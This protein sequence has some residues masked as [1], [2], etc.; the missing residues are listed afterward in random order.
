MKVL[1]VANQKGGVGKTTTAVN[2]GAALAGLGHRTLL[3]DLDPQANATLLAGVDPYAREESMYHVLVRGAPLRSVVTRSGVAGLDVAPAHI[4]LAGAEG[5]LMSTTGREQV[6]REALEPVAGDYAF[7]LID[8]QPSL[9]ILVVNALSAADEVVVPVEAGV[10]AFMGFRQ[11]EETVRLIQRRV[12]RR[13]KVAGVLV[14][15][16]DGRT[17]ERPGVPGAPPRRAR[18]ALPALRDPHRPDDA[19]QG[20]RESGPSRSSTATRAPRWRRSTSASRRS[21]SV[22]SRRAAARTR[23]DET[24]QRLVD[25]RPGV[26]DL[27]EGKRLPVAAIDANPQQP[28]KG[29]LEGIE[30]LAASIREY[31]LLQP[32]VVSPRPDGRYICIAGHRRLAAYRHLAA[33]EQDEPTRWAVIPAVERDDHSDEWLVLGLLENLSRSDL[34]DAEIISGLSVLHDLRGWHQ[35]EIARR[36]G[37]Q[38]VD[39]AVLPRR[40]RSLRQRVR[41]DRAALGGEGARHRAGQDARR[42][43]GGARRR[44][45]ECPAA[46]DPA[47]GEGRRGP[48]RAGRAGAA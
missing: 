3:V 39:H 37:V 1:A 30:E 42:P 38:R 46:R 17:T 19:G 8:C 24:W 36:L 33:T 13:L 34:T 47:A 20:R 35:G 16:F 26:E 23:A 22:A 10:F 41:A 43:A 15:K 45:P 6:L 9:G 11:L 18:R 29:P 44:A 5:E 48:G 4:D 31:G 28:R 12:N 25:N 27:L 14:T 7:A 40:R 2:L 32:I 21:S